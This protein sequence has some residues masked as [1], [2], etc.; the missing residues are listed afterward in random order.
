M[1][2]K[3]KIVF[4]G[5][6]DRAVIV[7]E[8]L[9]Q[10][11]LSPIF[12]V[13][14]P[15]RSAGRKLVKTAPP[16]KIWAGK[17]K[18]PV[19]Q[20]ENLENQMFLETLE[21]GNFDVFVVVAYGKILKQKILDIPK[22]GVLN[23]HASLLPR[24]RGSSPIETA[25]LTDEKRIGASIILLDALMDHGPIVSEREINVLN[26]P[27][28]AEKLSSILCKAGG[29]LLAE[30]IPLWL[31]GKIKAREQDHT[32]ATYTKKIKKEDGF[33]DF[34]A[35][36]YANYLKFLAYREWPTSYFFIEKSDRKIRVI[37]TDAIFEKGSFIIK[38]VIPEGRKEIAFEEFRKNYEFSPEY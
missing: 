5:T 22:Y 25:I 19:F 2:T 8:V 17:E 32:K 30:T 7:L 23:L 12:V 28:S 29:E 14:Q 9:K 11:N 16:V 18:I 15:D 27:V 34:S 31:S 35:P 26:W 3:P 33:I 21:K 4:F 24:L 36:P 38:K 20:P 6:P 13:T 37:V 1:T 10:A